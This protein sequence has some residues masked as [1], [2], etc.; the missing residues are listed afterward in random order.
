MGFAMEGTRQAGFGV[1]VHGASYSL[2]VSTEAGVRVI[3]L[4]T[5]IR[6]RR[7]TVEFFPTLIPSS[8]G[9]QSGGV[10]L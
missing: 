6:V 5:T 3:R 2:H 7:N 9:P 4:V 10:L 1:M 8:L